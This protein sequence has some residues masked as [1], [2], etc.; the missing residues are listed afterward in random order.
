M[1]APKP[2]AAATPPAQ[3][4]YL[5]GGAALGGGF[6]LSIIMRV[7]KIFLFFFVYRF[8]TVTKPFKNVYFL[9]EKPPI[10]LS[11]GQLTSGENNGKRVEKIH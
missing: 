3:A 8:C 11:I 5:H 7:S 10:F 6:V 2:G 4:Q 9:I 1:R